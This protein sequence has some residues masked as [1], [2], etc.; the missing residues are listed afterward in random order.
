LDN[1]HHYGAPARTPGNRLNTEIA[2]RRDPRTTRKITLMQLSVKGKQLDIGDALRAHVASS[3]ERILG[4][5]FGSVIET[6][7]TLSREA[8]HYRAVVFAHVG[9]HI[10]L[11]ANGEADQPY[12]AFDAAADRCGTITET[13]PATSRRSRPNST[14][15]PVNRSW[16]RTSITS[17]T[18]PRIS[19]LWS[20]KWPPR[21]PA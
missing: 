15:W 21:S 13:A 14:F 3:L 1:R 4:K 8:H 10:H 2:A 12:A 19:R 17:R 11:E 18:T 9:R 7:V 20:R 5:Y 16:T 6:R